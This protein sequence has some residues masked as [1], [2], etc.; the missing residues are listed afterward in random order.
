MTEPRARH[1]ISLAIWDLPS[2]VIVGRSVPLKVGISCSRRCCLAAA[3]IDVR[4]GSGAVVRCAPIGSDPW[5]GTAALYWVE[6]DVP[7]PAAEGDHEWTIE[8][9][10]P[11][12]VHPAITSTFRFMTSRPPEHRVTF[13]VIQQ[14]SG[15]PVG[16]VEL[17][18][19]AF[20][21]ATDDAGIAHLDVPG[22]TYDVCAWKTG[23]DL[24][25]TTAHVAGDTTVHLE[26][27]ATPQ[28]EQPYWM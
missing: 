12:A 2:P 23:H 4:D 19:G 25:S 9:S 28:P 8:A 27:V 6:L 3:S 1:E 22:G 26:V 14:G 17:R 24:L 16:G 15:V 10:A 20:R 18:V 13:N 7:A 11:D 21:S 5:P